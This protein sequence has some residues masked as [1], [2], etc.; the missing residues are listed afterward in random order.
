M[1]PIRNWIGGCLLERG[2]NDER[3]PPP[4]PSP[5]IYSET[6]NE[7]LVFFRP[8]VRKK[9]LIDRSDPSD[10]KRERTL[11]AGSINLLFSVQTTHVEA[12]TV[13]LGY[14]HS[15]LG[16]QD[17]AFIHSSIRRLEGGLSPKG[18][19]LSVEGEAS[20]TIHRSAASSNPS[21]LCRNHKAG[22]IS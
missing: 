13:C 6:A 11:P 22:R 7:E 3:H 9:E 12:A 18:I 19:D 16:N 20:L 14:Y 2:C 4:Q 17:W 5:P 8:W 15:S 1:P 21:R 10:E